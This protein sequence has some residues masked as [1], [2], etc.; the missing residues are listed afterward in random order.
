MNARMTKKRTTWQMHPRQLGCM[1]AILVIWAV[2]WA[3]VAWFAAYALF[4][5]HV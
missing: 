2:I 4:S 5:W 3:L 1:L